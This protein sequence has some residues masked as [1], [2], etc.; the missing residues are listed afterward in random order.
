MT[1]PPPEYGG[2]H[3]G[4]HDLVACGWPLDGGVCPSLKWNYIMSKFSDGDGAILWDSFDI[5]LGTLAQQTVVG[6]NSLAVKAANLQGFRILKSEIMPLVE[7]MTAGEGPV[8]YGAAGPQMTDAE[9]QE[10]IVSRPDSPN[11]S[12]ANERT[13]RPVWIWGQE[14]I[15]AGDAMVRQDP[16]IWKPRWSWPEGTSMRIW[17]FNNSNS[18]ALTTGASLTGIAKHYGVWLND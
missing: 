4:I 5:A 9:V 15:I 17:A 7:G 12:P 16:I 1:Y 3:G 6:Q 14:L 18:A 11:D 2:P 8:I 13:M 10:T